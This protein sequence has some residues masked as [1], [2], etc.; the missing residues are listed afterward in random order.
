M[1]EVVRGIEYMLSV[2]TTSSAFQPILVKSG[3]NAPL[4]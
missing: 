2:I 4:R 1:V 3:E